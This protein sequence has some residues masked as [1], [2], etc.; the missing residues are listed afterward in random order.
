MRRSGQLPKFVEPSSRLKLVL[1][2]SAPPY[3][4]LAQ[5]PQQ[6][7]FVLGQMLAT[8]PKWRTRR[9][10]YVR[11]LHERYVAGELSWDDV[12]ALRDASP[13]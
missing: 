11:Q 12:R 9:S 2:A 3:G 6:R 4:P 1:M 8:Y 13:S 7:A 10:A 5:T